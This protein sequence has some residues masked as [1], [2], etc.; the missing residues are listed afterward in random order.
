MLVTAEDRNGKLIPPEFFEQALVNSERAFEVDQWRLKKS[1][2]WMAANSDE[3]D[4]YSAV[5]VPL[6]HAS[7]RRDDL[8]NLIITELMDTAVP[9]GRI[10]FEI[11]DRDAI[12]NVTETAEFVRT[13][14]EFGC[15]FVLDEF[16]S[17]Q[18]NY[19]YVQELSVDF[20]TIDSGF[21]KDA[22]QDTKDFA[23]AK[24]INE[25]IHFMG[26]KTIGKQDPSTSVVNILR[27]IGVDFVYDKSV[28]HRIEV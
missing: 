22:A 4:S 16:G 8:A 17:G 13:L 9:P 15:R 26:K 25:L 18:G 3:I 2:R 24:S 10:F 19:D 21:I 6:S 14:K 27:E 1:L 20:V 5:I 23:M 7:V 12:A 11:T 28:T